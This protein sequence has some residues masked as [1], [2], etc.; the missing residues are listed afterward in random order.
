MSVLLQLLWLAVPILLSGLVHLVVLKRDLLPALR[1]APIDF[2]ATFRDR[3]LFGANKTWRGALVMI[4]GTAAFS[5]LLAQLNAAVLHWPVAVD[6]A[7]LHPWAWG[8]LLGT[9][10]ILGELPNS[11]IKRQLDIAPGAM[12]QGLRGRFF[13]VVDQLDSLVGIFLCVLPVWQ[14]SAGVVAASVFVML[15]VHPLSAW[16]MVLA[17]LKDRVG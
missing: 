5:A 6:Y 4:G 16:V 14:P 8:T 2:G 11:F 1:R 9:G 13:W 15:V 17:G 10:Y 7:A 12:G 3:R